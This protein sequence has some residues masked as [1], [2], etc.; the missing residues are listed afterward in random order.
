MAYIQFSQTDNPY[1][2]T[3]LGTPF[4]RGRTLDSGGHYKTRQQTNETGGGAVQVC[5]I[6]VATQF[7]TCNV[8]NLSPSVYTR[9]VNFL[10]DSTVRWSGY[11]FTFT[12]ENAVEYNVRWWGDT[13][14]EDPMKSQNINVT[15]ILR[16]E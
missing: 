12:D 16:V 11:A 7:I 5:D 10:K 2:L 9:L 4:A 1:N 14:P 15:M 6:G 13:L 8:D 3:N